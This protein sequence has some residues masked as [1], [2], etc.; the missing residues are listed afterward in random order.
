MPIRWIGYIVIALLLIVLFGFFYENSAQKNVPLIFSAST[1]LNATWLNY[2]KEYLDPGDYRTLDPSRDDVTTSE[3]ESYTMLRAVWLGDKTTYDEEDTW[4]KDNLQHK[5]DYLFSWE[6]GKEVNGSYGILTSDG[7]NNSASDADTDIALSLVMAYARWQDPQYLGDARDIIRSI[8][9]D[10]VVTIKGTPYLAADDLEKSS[11]SPTIVVDPSYFSPYAYRIFAEVDPSDPWDELIDSSYAVTGESMSMNLDASSSADIPPDWILI[12]KTT[13]VITAPSQS[14]ASS[15][16]SSMLTTNFGY[17]AIRVP[18]RLALD[19]QWYKDPRDKTLLDDM[20]FLSSTY[21]AT[22]RLD[23][24]YTHAGNIA[25]AYAYESDSMYGATIGYFMVANP[26][27]A[28][29]VYNDKL[30]ALYNPDTN[31]WKTQ[32][33]YYDDNWVWFGL[34]LYNNLLPNLAA[35]ESSTTL[36]TQ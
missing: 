30:L 14:A 34:A 28:T 32:L 3:G 33:S 10:E 22:G 12:N 17:N 24:V 26:S 2:K 21:T 16:S 13:G 1:L 7:G 25:P 20:G 15:S 36:A 4:I 5:T 23:A 8:W 29:S 27:L 11:T 35:S 9:A 18:F 6:F 31:A 19:Y